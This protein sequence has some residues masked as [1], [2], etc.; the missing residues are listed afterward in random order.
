[1]SKPVHV[2][3]IVEGQTEEAF[4]NRVL[5]PYLQVRQ[6]FMQPILL[7]KKGQKGGDVKFERLKTD[8][9]LYLCQSNVAAVTSLIDYY[10]L[11]EWPKK[12]EVPM[13][14]SPKQIA[15]LL[16]N[17]AKELIC[18]QYDNLNPTHRYLPFMVVHEFETLL[19]SDSAIL[20]DGLG[21]GKQ[22][23]DDI[24]SEAYGEPERINNSRE[25]APS[26]R[27]EGLKYNYDKV[28]DGF[29]IA[30]AIGIDKMREA[31]PL[32]NDWLTSIERLQEEA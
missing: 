16:N 9:H 14:A 18:Q 30:Q 24:L 31:C 10:G 28:S 8:V 1:M 29:A 20:A 13:N 22:R 32:F 27:I 23:V 4:V 25:T 2:K 12:D 6:I 26:K 19:F 7:S 17:A 3:V 11:K 15:D 21:I 5:A